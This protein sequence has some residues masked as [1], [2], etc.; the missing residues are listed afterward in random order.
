M[1]GSA[2]PRILQPG[3]NKIAIVDLGRPKRQ[4]LLLR[5][6]PRTKVVRDEPLSIKLSRPT[7]ISGFSTAARAS[8]VWIESAEPGNTL[9]KLLR[10]LWDMSTMPAIALVEPLGKMFSRISDC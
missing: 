3:E 5:Y 6:T 10:I 9:L 4:D 7:S 2:R 8:C 1:N